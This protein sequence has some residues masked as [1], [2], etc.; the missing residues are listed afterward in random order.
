MSIEKRRAFLIN[1]VY[2]ALII[3][4]VFVLVRYG[5]P[6]LAP[7]VIALVISYLLQK[8]IRWLVRRLHLPGKAAAIFAVLLFY[9]AAGALISLLGIR[10][11]SA[12]ADF[13][14]NLPTLYEEEI[15]PFFMRI[16]SNMETF[17]LSM[18]VSTAVLEY[19]ARQILQSLQQMISGVSVSAMGAVSGFAYSIPGLFIKLV[20]LIIATFFISIDYD[21]LAGFCLRQM[22]E[23]TK[24]LVLEIKEYVVGTLWVCIR[25]Y[26]LIMSITFVELS[27]LLGFFAGVKH[28]VLIALCISIFDILPV[29][30]T[31]GIMIPWGV[32]S[33]LLGDFG[34]GLKLLLIYVIITVIR[35][36][37]EPK[38]VGGQL[39]LHP[40]VTLASMFAGV[41]LLGVIGLFGFP[42]LLSLLRHLNNHGVIKVMKPENTL[43]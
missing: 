41:Q 15:L 1:F 20:L 2:F 18:N 17:L 25:S 36:I 29:L 12:L 8:P 28:A 33:L 11:F 24:T 35:N 26:V 43:I 16:L 21:R 38:I 31:G 40:V 34:L 10:A 4:A 27:V 5:M 3:G 30:G 37:L 6:M 39:G 19:L 22:N 32:L 42:I 23:K 9:A 13:L 14:G 7:F